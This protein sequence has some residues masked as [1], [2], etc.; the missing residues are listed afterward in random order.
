[1]RVVVW[2][3]STCFEIDDSLIQVEKEAI[4]LILIRYQRQRWISIFHQHH[5]L[6]L[7]PSGQCSHI[8]SAQIQ[9]YRFLHSH[10]RFLALLHHPHC[11]L[12]IVSFPVVFPV[13]RTTGRNRYL[14]LHLEEKKESL[15]RSERRRGGLLV[16]EIRVGE[17]KMRD[18]CE[19]RKKSLEEWKSRVGGF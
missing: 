7:E 18:D 11:S 10:T 8:F 16:R 6:H 9:Q 12:V 2:G 13:R 5:L 3:R 17:R 15:L 19:V 14:S 4:R 1:M